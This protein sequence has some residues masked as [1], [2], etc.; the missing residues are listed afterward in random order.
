MGLRKRHRFSLGL[1]STVFQT[2]IYAIKACIMENRDRATH[3]T[4]R[5]I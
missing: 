4:G 2:E 1:H 3:Y 5:N